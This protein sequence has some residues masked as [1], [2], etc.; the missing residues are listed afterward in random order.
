MTFVTIQRMTSSDSLTIRVLVD[1]VSSFFQGRQ[2]ALA[3]I[4][5]FGINVEVSTSSH[6]L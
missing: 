6:P 5:G 3:W 1:A 2:P 4:K